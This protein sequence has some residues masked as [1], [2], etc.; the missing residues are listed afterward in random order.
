MQGHLPEGATPRC[1]LQQHK[2]GS[3]LLQLCFAL[4]VSQALPQPCSPC[5]EL[6]HHCARSLLSPHHWPD[7]PPSA[8]ALGMSPMPGGAFGTSSLPRLQ[9]APGGSPTLPLAPD[10][11]CSSDGV[12]WLGQKMNDTGAGQ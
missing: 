10:E 1:L 9:G 4:G 2:G 8:T 7:S 6:H 12:E 11:L 3:T 5:S